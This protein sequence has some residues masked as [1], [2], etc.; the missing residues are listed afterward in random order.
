MI[1]LMDRTEQK[2]NNKRVGEKITITLIT[3]KNRQDETLVYKKITGKV[4]FENTRRITLNTGVYKEDFRK[5]DYTEGREEL[6]RAK[7]DKRDA[8]FNKL[9]DL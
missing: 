4:V 9:Y 2:A 6:A 5:T 8:N 3:E 1:K 7:E